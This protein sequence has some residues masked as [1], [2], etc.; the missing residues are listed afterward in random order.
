MG[1]EMTV[2]SRTALA[3]ASEEQGAGTL[4]RIRLFLPE[5]RGVSAPKPIAPRVGYAGMRRR[6]L[7]VDNEEVDRTLLARRLQALGFEVLEAGSG[8]AAL[9]LLAE[10]SVDAILMDLA[11][12]GIDGWETVRTLRRLQ[13]SSAPVA[14]VSANA[15]DKGQDNDVGIG[16]ADFV[17][18]PV[19]FDELLD[20]MGTKLALQ[21]LT[22]P[23]APSGP[24]APPSAAVPANA[25]RPTREQLQAL[26]EVVSLGYPRGVHKLLDQIETNRPDTA[27]WLAPLRTLAHNFQ[28]DRMTP[29]IQHALAH[30]QPT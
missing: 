13:L 22:T 18:K 23:P 1:G 8:T 27:A 6:I 29:V 12:P 28:F 24:S 21:W 26:H 15:F 17:T 7:L 19:R 20:W 16:A 25:P 5:L 9:G 11:M 14:I 30:A 3:G 2:S 10:N 4:F